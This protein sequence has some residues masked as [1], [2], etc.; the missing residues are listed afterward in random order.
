MIG[1]VGIRLELKL[2]EGAFNGNGGELSESMR[3]ESFG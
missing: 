1:E 3:P 2:V